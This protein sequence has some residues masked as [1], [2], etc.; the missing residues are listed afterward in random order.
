MT[1]SKRKGMVAVL[2]M[3]TQNPPDQVLWTLN[4]HGQRMKRSGLR[5]RT[6]LRLHALNP[7]IEDLETLANGHQKTEKDKKKI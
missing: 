3:S 6:G 1:P 4:N 7:L 2:A 5:R